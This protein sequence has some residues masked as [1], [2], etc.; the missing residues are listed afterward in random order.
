ML[1]VARGE[2][3]G[4]GA[5]QVLARQVRPRER[6]R[7]SVLQ[8]VAEAVGAARLVEARARPDPT[9]ERLVEQ[10]AVQHQV[11]RAIGRR[12]LD[13]SED[14]V[15]RLHGAAE[16]RVEVRAPVA[17]DQLARLLGR[18]SLAE[19][20]HHLGALVRAQL[21]ARLSR[22]GRGARCGPRSRRAAGPRGRRTRRVRRARGSRDCGR[23]ARRSRRRARSPGTAP[24]PRARRRGPTRRRP[25]PR[26]DARAT[27][28]CGASGARS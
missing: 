27:N 17:R 11:E 5:E 4:G 7:H 14:V 23:A 16:D 24:R 19:Q 22:C 21:E 10:P 20:E 9:G 1:D 15:P 8:L 12:D 26:G 2:L 25:S 28:G 13:G 6:E 18:R 3:A